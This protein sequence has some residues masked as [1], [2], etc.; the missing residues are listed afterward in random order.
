MLA[1]RQEE[2]ARGGDQRE[3]QDLEPDGGRRQGGC[4][5]PYI[6]VC[7]DPAKLV[8]HALDAPD[9]APRE[10]RIEQPV[11]PVDPVVE[12]QPAMRH[13]GYR[14]HGKLIESGSDERAECVKGSAQNARVRPS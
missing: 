6:E 1:D 10:L 7:R 14:D 13:H 2:Q 9:V 4:G 5:H 11:I 3:R 8:S 12:D